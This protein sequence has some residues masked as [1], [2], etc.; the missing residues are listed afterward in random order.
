MDHNTFIKYSEESYTVFNLYMVFKGQIPKGVG[1]F[2]KMLMSIPDSTFVCISTDGKLLYTF[3]TQY[4]IGGFSYLSNIN[5]PSLEPTGFTKTSATDRDHQPSLPYFLLTF[6]HGCILLSGI[7]TYGIQF[8]NKIAS[9]N[10]SQDDRNL[11]IWVTFTD[12]TKTKIA[13]DNNYLI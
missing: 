13:L 7:R 6:S 10:V 1:K 2:D 5:M 4:Q 9:V 3:N 11:Y 12:D 8:D